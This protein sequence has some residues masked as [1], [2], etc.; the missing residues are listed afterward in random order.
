MASSSNTPPTLTQ[1]TPLACRCSIAS[2]RSSS[3]SGRQPSAVTKA[4]HE[5]TLT[6]T[7]G[8]IYPDPATL[9]FASNGVLNNA[10]FYAAQITGG[11]GKLVY[12]ASVA[13][14]AIGAYN[15]G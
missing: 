10:P 14:T 6:H 9:S 13:E 4:L 8:N 7:T 2:R 1:A 12:P 11:A 15:G 5:V 3:V